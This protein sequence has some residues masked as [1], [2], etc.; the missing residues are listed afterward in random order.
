MLLL[1]R[2]TFDVFSVRCRGGLA[3]R[4][5]GSQQALSQPPTWSHHR[6]DHK[7]STANCVEICHCVQKEN[8]CNLCLCWCTVLPTTDTCRLKPQRNVDL[9]VVVDHQES[10]FFNREC[11]QQISR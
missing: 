11:S 4:Q 1:C 2:V 9:V 5:H 6:A 10:P 3:V 8:N 7:R